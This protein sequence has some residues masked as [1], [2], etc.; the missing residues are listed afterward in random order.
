MNYKIVACIPARY[1]STRL[2]GKPLLK[3]KDKTIIN[4]VYDRVMQSKLIDMVYILTDDVRIEQ[5]VIR[6]GGNCIYKNI[7]CLNGTERICKSL[8]FI[9]KNYTIIVNIQGD[10]PFIDPLNIDKCI[11]NFIEKNYNHFVCSTLHAKIDYNEAIKTSIGKLVLDHNNN[12]M[13][14]SRTP[15]PSTKSGKINQTINYYGHIGLF[16]FNRDYLENHYM[17]KNYPY[18]LSEDIEWLKIIESGNRINSVCVEFSEISVD[19]E[20]DYNYLVAKYS[21]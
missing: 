10:E 1:K 12:I 7:D 15:I 11:K 20:E 6:F 21:S 14:C 17:E 19:T 13:Y 8:E 16:V 9:D 4:R 18:Q 5:E 2:P 3:I